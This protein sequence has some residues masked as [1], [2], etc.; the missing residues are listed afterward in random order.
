MGAT[1]LLRCRLDDRAPAV[2]G[3][4]TKAT[5]CEVCQEPRVR[6]AKM[7]SRREILT[8]GLGAAAGVFAPQLASA[9]AAGPESA[10]VRKDRSIPF[11]S[12]VRASAL[13]GDKAY[14]AA[15]A[16]NCQWL[17]RLRLRP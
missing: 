7:K 10:A 4:M 2:I 6:D 1:V 14:Q 9:T 5:G 16:E 3:D 13:R 17:T 11:G 8:D 12:A 15:V